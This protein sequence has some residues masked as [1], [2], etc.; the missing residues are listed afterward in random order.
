VTSRRATP[1]IDYRPRQPLDRALALARERLA[2]LEPGGRPA[3]PIDVVSASQIEVRAEST[4]CLRCQGPNRVD[5]HTAERLEGERVR[6][7][8][9][10]CGHCGARRTMYFR[11][12][13]ASS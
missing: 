3:H 6:V 11:V 1:V 7:V 5:E 12:M 8:R 2:L 9:V 10:H 13:P 4:P